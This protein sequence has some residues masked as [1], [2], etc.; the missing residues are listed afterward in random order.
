VRGAITGDRLCRLAL[1]AIVLLVAAQVPFPA[2]AHHG[3]RSIGALFNC[4]RP[5]I[6]PR[7]TSVAHDML[8]I[9]AFDAS[10]TD[11]LA[12]S[13]RDTMAEDYDP[14]DFRMVETHEVVAA[15]DVIVYSEDYGDIG[16]A[17]WVYC[18]SDAPQGINSEGDRW[19]RHQELRLNLNPRYNAF[20]ADDA[21][22]D[23]VTCHELGHTI[24]LRHWG[25]PPE[26][27]GPVAA[28]CMNADTPN[29]PTQLHQIDIDHINAYFY[30][31][32]PPSRRLRPFDW[33]TEQPQRRTNSFSNAGV[34]AMEIEHFT[35]LAEITGA[36][37]AVVRGNVTSVAP[38]RAFGDPD[39]SPLHYGAVTL[40]VEELVAGSLAA[41]DTVELILEVPLFDGPESIAVLDAGLPDGE[42]LF[43]LRD[44]G[45]SAAEAGMSVEAQRSDAGYYRL[46]VFGAVVANEAG[47]A[48]AG[49]GESTALASIDGLG[50]EVAVARTRAAGR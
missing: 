13:L 25:N 46:V 50:F 31:A 7:C 48:R 20:F 26:S 18:P 30:V 47:I 4:D 42:A 1:V 39:A 40:R 9:V 11:G 44:K 41:A 3:G 33:S 28:T 2:S 15:T 32:P 27:A 12:S 43:F 19:C 8:H 23:Y 37:D 17:G 49:G 36:A 14:T 35:S 16:A 34:A 5:V 21:S 24:G 29:G 38:G 22:R 45:A 6:P 10:L